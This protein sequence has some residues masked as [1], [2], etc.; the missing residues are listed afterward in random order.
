M[1]ATTRSP[2]WKSLDQAQALLDQQAQANWPQLL[3]AC[4]LAANPAQSEILGKVSLP[5]LL[6]GQ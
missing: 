6:V 5:L 1:R 4:A 2:G 3:D